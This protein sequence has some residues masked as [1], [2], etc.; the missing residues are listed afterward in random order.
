MRTTIITA[1]YD[2]YDDLKPILPQVG[3]VDWVCVTDAPIESPGGWRVVVEPRPGQHPNVAAKR[4]KMLPWEYTHAHQSIWVDASF[5]ITSPTFA[6]EA[7]QVAR[8]IAQFS[9][10]WRDCVY[11]EAEASLA[12]PKYQG[13]PIERQMAHHRAHQHPQHWGLWATGVIA[14]IHAPNV[15]ALGESWLREC[16]EWSFQDQL[17]QAPH[18]RL[19]GLRPDELTGSHLKNPWL[20][21]Q[22]SSRH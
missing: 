3:E 1:I 21:Y 17:S 6:L 20:S 19:L 14:R 15:V 13:L 16:Q 11:E 18:L 4:P 9:H 5:Q 2:N 12:L 10:P 7:M 8:P 22:G